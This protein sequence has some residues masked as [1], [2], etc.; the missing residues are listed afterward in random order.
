M[1]DIGDYWRDHKEYAR[2][3]KAADSL[4][5]SLSQYRRDM[6]KMEAEERAEKKVAKLATHTIRCEC[7]R[8]FLDKNAHNCHKTRTG[9][10]GHKGATT[11]STTGERESEDERMLCLQSNGAF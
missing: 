8:T 4:G 2:D 1:G 3:R 9:K 5:V 7:G 11:Q 10:L 6:R